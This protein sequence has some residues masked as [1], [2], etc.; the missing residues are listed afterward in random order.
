MYF[1]SLHHKIKLDENF[2]ALG[3][4]DDHMIS[5]VQG[6]Q[7]VL[8]PKFFSPTRYRQILGLN[9][10]HFPNLAPRFSFRGK[11]NQC[12]LFRAYNVPHPQT[13]IFDS[14]HQAL[15]Q[16]VRKGL[17][18]P[19]P[20]V[21]KGDTGAGGSAVFPI[22]N[23]AEYKSGLERLPSREPV[24][25]QEWINNQGKDLRVVKVGQ[26]M[27]SYFRISDGSFHNNVA[28]G[29]RIDHE[30][31]PEKQEQGK[32]LVHSVAT[33]TRIDI[34]G[35]DVMFSKDHPPL[36]IEINF[37]FGTKGLGGYKGY[38]YML[39]EA[40]NQWIK[41]LGGRYPYLTLPS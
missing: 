24:L 14:P 7:G 11:A 5:L 18:R 1:V 17:P 21:L 4:W 30:L 38:Q 33:R 16:F 28:Q 27:F 35:F 37:L 29:G 13:Q 32:R 26:V 31:A 20:F 2:S 19:L 36:I 8:M 10:N 9:P 34:A 41:G 40:I 12:R 23:C 15:E 3:F 39:Y 6:A 22:Q 25:V